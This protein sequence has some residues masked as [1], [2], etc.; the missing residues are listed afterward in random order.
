M[1]HLRELLRPRRRTRLH[2][3]QPLDQLDELLAPLVLQLVLVAAQHGLEDREKGGRQL[4]DGLVFPLVCSIVSYNGTFFFFSSSAGE[5]GY[6]HSWQIMR[7]SG[8]FSS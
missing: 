3:V 6:I 8:S 5:S 4:L 1:V 2:L 7:Y